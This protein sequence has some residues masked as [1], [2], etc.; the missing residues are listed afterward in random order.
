[1]CE[2]YLFI[3][4]S[5]FFLSLDLFIIFSRHGERLGL[6]GKVVPAIAIEHNGKHWAFDEKN[7]V[8]AES[9]ISWVN[10]VCLCVCVCVFSGVLSVFCFKIENNGKHWA[11]DE[12]NSV[13]AESVISWVNQVCLSVFPTQVCICLFMWYV[14]VC[15]CMLCLFVCLFIYL[16]I[17]SFIHFSIYLFILVHIWST[18]RNRS[19]RRNPNNTNFTCFKIGRKKLGSHCW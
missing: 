16:F 17:P 1:V 3:Y 13:T 18:H 8:T 11:F 4:F 9:V 10:Q 14:F 19:F 12:K 7:S 2:I 5:F 6:S 15:F